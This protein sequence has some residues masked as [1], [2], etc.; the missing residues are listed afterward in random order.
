[1]QHDID[2]VSTHVPVH[3]LGVNEIGQE[4]GNDGM[5]QGRTIP[6][7]QDLPL[8]DVWQSW[9]VTM[10]D[11]VVLNAHNDVIEIYNLTEHN[12]ADPANYATLRTFLIEAARDSTHASA[13]GIGNPQAM[14]G[15]GR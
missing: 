10:R 3:F 1:M 5:C 11:V 8:I 13:L 9:H 15:G 14:S 4:S 2:T 7:L 6:W 12:L